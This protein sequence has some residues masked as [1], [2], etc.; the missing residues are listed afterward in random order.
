MKRKVIVLVASMLV[1]F[2]ASSPSMAYHNLYGFHASHVTT[3]VYSCDNDS[4]ATNVSMAAEGIHYNPIKKQNIVDGA[5]TAHSSRI[6]SGQKKTCNYF[7]LFSTYGYVVVG[8]QGDDGNHRY[9]GYV[10]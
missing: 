7:N 6:C 1:L 5:N 8:G 9:S 10:S 2:G 4:L 3:A